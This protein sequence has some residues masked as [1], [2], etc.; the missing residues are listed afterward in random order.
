MNKNTIDRSQPDSIL[1]GNLDNT[2]P[3]LKQNKAD[4]DQKKQGSS[5]NL[6]LWLLPYAHVWGSAPP[7]SREGYEGGSEVR[8]EDATSRS[9][10][11]NTGH[12]HQIRLTVRC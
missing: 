1:K 11:T 8:G 2:Q 12:K 4:Y 10:S 7:G 9:W 5:D 3:Y 6:F